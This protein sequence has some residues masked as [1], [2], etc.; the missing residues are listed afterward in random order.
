LNNVNCQWLGRIFEMPTLD[1]SDY[2]RKYLKNK[3]PQARGT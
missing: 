3:A 2:G 1:S